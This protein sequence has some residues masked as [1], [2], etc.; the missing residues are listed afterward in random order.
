MDIYGDVSGIRATQL[1]ELKTLILLRTERPELIHTSLLEGMCSLTSLWNKEVALYIN[2]SGIVDAVAVGQHAAVKLPP[3]SPRQA[4]KIRCIH[5]HPSGHYNLSPVDFSA[6]TSLGLE[7]M[8]SVGVRKGKVT[9][10]EIAFITDAGTVESIQLSPE[11]IQSFSY[12]SVSRL[13]KASQPPKKASE[14]ELAYLVA[15]DEEEEGRELLAELAELARTAGVRVVGQILQAK[16]YGSSV[17][18]IG[19]GKL[20]E[21]THK[22]QNTG[23]NLLICDDELTPVQ[24]RTLEKATGIKVLDRT[25]LILDIFAQR[26]RSR[27]GKLQVELA[28]LK[29]LLPHLTGQ[30]QNLS[31]LGGGVGTRGPGE[32]KL[33]VDRR[34]VR[35]KITLLEEQL[36]EIRKT[37]TTQRRQR[38][39]SGIPLIA[40]VG[41]TNAGKT[42]FLQKAMDL[43]HSKGDRVQGEDKLFATL[44]PIVRGIKI[45]QEIEILLSDTVGFIQKL[46]HHLLH[47]FLATLE[48]VKNADVL[49]HVLDASHPKALE[50]ADTV[51][52]ILE[53]LECAQKPRITL[54]NKIDQVS[55]LSELNRLAQE[56]SHPI[57]ISLVQEKSLKPVWNKIFQLLPSD[58]LSES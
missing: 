34:R 4:A 13:T 40:L 21:L 1:K 54:L 18:Y 32:T 16:R 58:S 47:A 52:R 41:Y 35:Q 46:P 49:I 11:D 38:L 27:E 17:S 23:A 9:G 48:E 37:R 22:L 14:E 43:T 3:I 33:E 39:K 51:H 31:R 50:R 6:L 20:E 25:T 56:L 30:G 2:R 15:L 44:D 24:T 5:T 12:D 8:T 19:K 29:H 53:E 45:N 57:P 10:C 55:N 26:A 7:S 36:R 42:T 28:Q